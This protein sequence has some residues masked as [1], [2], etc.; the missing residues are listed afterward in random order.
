MNN[1]I[2]VVD[3]SKHVQRQIE[4]FLIP[5]GFSRLFFV[6]SAQEAFHLLGLD[7]ENSKNRKCEIDLILMDINMPGTNGVEACLKINATRHLKNI[8]IIVITA[9]DTDEGLKQAFGAGAI[10][11]IKKP[12]NPVELIARVSSVLKLKKEMDERENREKELLTLAQ[13]LE[14]TNQEL[15]QAN[16]KLHQLSRTDSLTGL[17]NRRFFDEMLHN[18]WKQSVR[19]AKPLS[20]LMIDIDFFKNYN[21][22]YGHQKGDECLKRVSM[23]IL[24]A[25]KRECD[26]I[27]RYGGEEFVALLSDTDESGAV[28]VAKAMQSNIEAMNIP[29]KDSNASG[30]IT[31]SIGI[32]NEVPSAAS[33]PEKL[34]SKADK[35][36]YL[37]K[38]EGRNL[39]KW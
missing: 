7:D 23:A 35:A 24:S 3:D 30:R 19:L 6:N 25:L 18:E 37:A 20:L 31:V 17:A 22:T 33:S 39:I 13:V 26:I 29:H 21:D 36:L 14:K 8:P 15:Q 1:P 27:A 34:I 10:D 28:M 2:L 32:S 16:E 9:E 4:I 12:L 38:Y 5:E 11:Y